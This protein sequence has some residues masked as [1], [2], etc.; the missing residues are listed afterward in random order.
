MEPQGQKCIAPDFKFDADQCHQRGAGFLQRLPV[1]VCSERISGSCSGNCQL[2]LCRG[3]MLEPFGYSV[4]HPKGKDGHDQSR[5]QDQVPAMG[6]VR[7]CQIKR[8]FETPQRTG[9]CGAI[10]VHQSIREKLIPRRALR[11]SILAL[12]G[13][14]L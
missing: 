4:A 13:P 3:R 11:W 8:G 2:C 7:V 9:F 12:H 14:T 6:F 5:P 10:S 1:Q